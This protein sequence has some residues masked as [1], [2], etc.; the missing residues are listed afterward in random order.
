M[1]G[2]WLTAIFLK[3]KK[4]KKSNKNN[5]NVSL[6]FKVTINDHKFLKFLNILMS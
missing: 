6:Y 5:N 3:N 1:N 2:C 4:K